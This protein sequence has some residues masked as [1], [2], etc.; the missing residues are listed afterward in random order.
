M[1][2][3]YLARSEVGKVRKNNQD[4]GLAS[5]SILA[6]ADG[7]GG[8]A[9]GDLAAAVAIEAIR[10]VSGQLDGPA[11]GTV[12]DDS[13]PTDVSAADDGPSRDR[14][15][16]SEHLKAPE[17]PEGIRS[18]P[19]STAAD[20]AVGDGAADDDA[21]PL[22]A[23][24][25]AIRLANGRIAD[26]IAAEQS[27]EGMGATA[28]V[29]VLD[30]DVIR[31]AHI[32][33]SRA[34]LL[35]DGRLE[36][37]SHDHSWVQ[38]LIDDGKITP[39]EATVHP[40]RSLLLKV[41]NGQP[42]SEPDL[43][44][45][46][47]RPGDRMLLCSDG[48]CGFVADSVIEEALAG[49]SRDQ[50]MDRLVGA[51]YETGGL[52]NITI[53]VADL[54]GDVDDTDEPVTGTDAPGSAGTSRAAPSNDASSVGRPSSGVE[55]VAGPGPEP[56]I[57]GAASNHDAAAIE[58]AIGRRAGS[59]G[60]GGGSGGDG[61]SDEDRYAPQLPRK[62]RFL[63]P[64][65]TIAVAVIV[66]AAAAGAGFAW[67]RTQ[68][69]VGADDEHVAI[70]Q[71]LNQSVPG[72]RLSRVYEVQQVRM[73]HLPRYYQDM[74]R[75]T[76]SAENLSE[77]RGTVRQL[78]DI[79]ERCRSRSGRNKQASSPSPSATTSSKHPTKSATPKKSAT[80]RTS[81]TPRKSAT[82][83]KSPTPTVTASGHLPGE[84]RC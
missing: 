23:L 74:V 50:A 58:A 71:G 27:L 81:A 53:I 29:A 68:Y 41:I 82:P 38:S 84:G 42:A 65:I 52:D 33:D 48:L 56:H 60:S 21:A 16:G 17:K 14:A 63:R 72:V 18:V 80:P 69:Y 12:G 15:G 77:A 9:A 62:R 40:H 22:V 31:L 57:L 10:S 73:N 64:L 61:A 28:T 46:S 20:G 43:E 79:A 70:Y 3:R 76:I 13:N 47:V 59:A 67:A 37:L 49:T 1:R 36:Q 54:F 4:A 55:Q 34:Y 35:R 44:T 66:L 32:G 75:G 5:G 8:A 24:A 26:L 51:A 6:V 19:T 7:M 39:E 30:D 83:E 11:V 78:H 2:W 45:V 25:E